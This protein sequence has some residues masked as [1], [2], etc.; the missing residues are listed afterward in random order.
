MLSQLAKADSIQGGKY[1]YHDDFVLNRIERSL[2]EQAAARVSIAGLPRIA[3]TQ[4]M[5][6]AAQINSK[7]L[8][9]VAPF[10]PDKAPKNRLSQ[11]VDIALAAFKGGVCVSAN[12]DFRGFDSHANNDPDQMTLIPQLL[13]AI[14]YLVR[15]A[16]DLKIREKLVIVMQ[17]EMGRTPSYNK[18]NGKDHWSVGSLMFMGRGIRGNRVVGSTTDKQLVVPLNPKSLATD[19]K[20][21][22][23]IRPE[24]IHDALRQLAGINS[25]AFSK[26][27][28]LN[29]P[30]QE[31]LHPLWTVKT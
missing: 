28:P 21:G 3:R 24:H 6:Y 11:Q 7:A 9:R 26:Q 19:K 14:D 8:R 2:Q 27:F 20:K 18:G 15:K 17:S 4:S 16:E 29:I 23:H 12:L 25:H 30:K 22:I 1:R 13:E 10:V 31:S 5:L